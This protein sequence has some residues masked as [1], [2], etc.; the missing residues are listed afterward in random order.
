MYAKTVTC[1]SWQPSISNS[2]QFKSN[3]HVILKKYAIQ[4][5][6]YFKIK[7]TVERKLCRKVTKL[8]LNNVKCSFSDTRI[9]TT[10]LIVCLLKMQFG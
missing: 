4:L 3:F 1:L 8:V 5:N 6:Y 10:F 7:M 2:I 9:I